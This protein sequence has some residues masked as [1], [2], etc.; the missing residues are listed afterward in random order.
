MRRCGRTG[1]PLPLWLHSGGLNAPSYTPLGSCRVAWVGRDLFVQRNAGIRASDLQRKAMAWRV[2]WGG[3]SSSSCCRRQTC[4]WSSQ[5]KLHQ[6]VNVWCWELSVFSTLKRHFIFQICR[7]I[8]Y[9]CLFLLRGNKKRAK[10][11]ESGAYPQTSKSGVQI[12][13]LLLMRRWGF[14]EALHPRRL[15]GAQTCGSCE[16]GG[17]GADLPQLLPVTPSCHPSAA[18]RRRKLS[19]NV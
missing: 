3:A 16:R 12:V 8:T 1:T 9:L 4:L 13:L 11:A 19:R 5:R 18:G 15:Q 17:G 2:T 6:V 7:E 14:N 10:G